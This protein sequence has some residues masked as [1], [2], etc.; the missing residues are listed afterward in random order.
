MH[1]KD[2]YYYEV[3][4]TLEDLLPEIRP[5]VGPFPTD[6]AEIGVDVHL[7]GR[8]YYAFLAPGKPRR[9]PGETFIGL[10]LLDSTAPRLT[11]LE[12]LELYVANSKIG[13]ARILQRIER[14][15]PYGGTGP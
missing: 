4:V 14:K 5:S 6:F 3:E 9:W 15:W 8:R 12:D 10:L 11:G 7:R 1:P 13:T 2:P